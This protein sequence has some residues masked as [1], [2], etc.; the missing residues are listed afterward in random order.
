M[1][2]TSKKKKPKVDLEMMKAT[3]WYSSNPTLGEKIKK[4]QFPYVSG[5]DFD[6][7]ELT[8]RVLDVEKW[9]HKGIKA[10]F[11]IMIHNQMVLKYELNEIRDMLNKIKHW[12]DV[13]DMLDKLKK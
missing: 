7:A 8:L 13:R 6:E 12:N 10:R 9:G 11:D 1:T 5:K 4:M 2:K 3:V